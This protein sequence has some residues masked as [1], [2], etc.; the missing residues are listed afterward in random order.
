MKYLITSSLLDSFDWLKNCPKSWQKKAMDDFIGML[1][2]E[3]RPTSPECQRG[4]DFED[5]VCRSGLS[6]ND[7]VSHITKMYEEKGLN[8]EKLNK[9]VEVTS[10]IYNLCISG[11]QQKKLMKD[12][13]VDG[14]EYHLFGYADIVLPNVIYDIKTTTHFKGD[15]AYLKRSQHRIYSICTEIEYFDY[16]VADYNGS[17]APQEFYDV[18]ASTNLDEDIEVIS[19]RIR[20]L[21]KFIDLSGLRKDYEEIFTAEHKDNK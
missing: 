3:K 14:K 12:I 15:E 19:N 5:L 2:R 4:I 9:A 7:F 6:Y 1:R 8:G 10:K 18:Y 20:Q 16:L 17:N 11:E 21:M 13:V